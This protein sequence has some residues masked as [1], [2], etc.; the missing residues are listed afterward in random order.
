[1]SSAIKE[2][3]VAVKNFKPMEK[4]TV[5]SELE[6]PRPEVLRVDGKTIPV[7]HDAIG[8]LCSML[9]PTMPMGFYM[10]LA[11]KNPRAWGS[12][13][14]ALKRQG[15]QKCVLVASKGTIITIVPSMS[16]I[17]PHMRVLIQVRWILDNEEGIKLSPKGTHFDGV[18]LTCQ[19]VRGL[20]IDTGKTREGVPDT[21]R[22]GWRL[23][24]RYA[25]RGFQASSGAERLVC[26]NL[27]YLPM[28]AGG[29]VRDVD[30]VPDLV[31]HTK[32]SLADVIKRRVERMKKVNTSVRE[33]LEAYK[34]LDAWNEN[35]KP[36]FDTHRL[37]LDEIA[38][39]YRMTVEELV[40]TPMIWKATA[41]TPFKYYDLYN[42]ITEAGVKPTV[43]IQA[44]TDMRIEGG[45]MMF[46]PPDLSARAAKADFD[47]RRPWLLSEN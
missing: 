11:H 12:L 4:K 31:M 13:L 37:R 25:P 1:M 29:L 16:A 35:R 2:L 38:N 44:A 19:L 32:T 43:S 21:F 41:E 3:E 36:V 17:T 15:R 28:E 47:D 20:K 24:N 7:T 42:F 40:K 14:D 39:A 6:F 5:L 33:V 23:T 26:G 9:T 10:K 45:H 18:R 34:T 22:L 46:A 27:S 8:D 30:K